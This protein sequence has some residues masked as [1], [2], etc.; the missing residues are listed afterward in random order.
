M[1][2][3]LI[4]NNFTYDR[5][6]S[7]QNKL[8]Y[9]GFTIENQCVMWPWLWRKRCNHYFWHKRDIIHYHVSFFFLNCC[10]IWMVYK[11][12][13]YFFYVRTIFL[14]MM[15]QVHIL[16]RSFVV[17]VFQWGRISKSRFRRKFCCTFKIYNNIALLNSFAV[18]FAL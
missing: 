5:F 13:K 17:K 16:S 11:W 7:T 2:C 14:F 4:F 12:I 8:Q 6:I 3:R 10:S 18:Y 9:D 1:I 15:R